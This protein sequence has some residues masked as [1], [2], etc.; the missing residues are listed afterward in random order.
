MIN[1]NLKSSPFYQNIQGK[2]DDLDHAVRVY[3][4]IRVLVFNLW[5][6]LCNIGN[7]VGSRLNRIYEYTILSKYSRKTLV[8]W[9][10]CACVRSDQ[11]PSVLACERK[12]AI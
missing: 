9:S 7:N 4:L 12:Y 10:Y 3:G 8:P 5:T 1:Q 6:K 2:H 11:G